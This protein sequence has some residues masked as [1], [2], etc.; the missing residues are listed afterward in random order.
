MTKYTNFCHDMRRNG[1]KSS[2]KKC[3]ESGVKS[4]KMRIFKEF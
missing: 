2:A 4:R 3:R 1:K